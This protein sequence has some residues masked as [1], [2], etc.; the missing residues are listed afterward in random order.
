MLAWQAASS[1]LPAAFSCIYAK[2]SKCMY[3]ACCS[4]GKDYPAEGRIVEHIEGWAF[5]RFDFDLR[6]DSQEH[7][8]DYVMELPRHYPERNVMR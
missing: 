7:R 1:P 6:L 3:K 2:C 5:W 8:V 4:V